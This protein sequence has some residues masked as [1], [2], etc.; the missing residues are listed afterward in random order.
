M[1]VII[2]KKA[3]ECIDIFYRA[4]MQNHPLLSEETVMKKKQRLIASLNSLGETPTLYAKSR[5]KKEWISNGWREY[6]CED[7][8]FAYEICRDEVEG[9]FVWVH[10]AEHSLLY[11]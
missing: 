9:D 1:R 3:I 11:Y 7:F 10:D 5:L 2:E 8:H 4:A 6:L